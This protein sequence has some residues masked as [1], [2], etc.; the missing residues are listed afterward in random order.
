MCDIVVN[1]VF[2]ELREENNRLSDDLSFE[3]KLNQILEKIKTLAIILKNN[4][5]CSDNI[6]VFRQ[7]NDL[8]ID[9]KLVKA[10]RIGQH[11]QQASKGIL[12]NALLFERLNTRVKGQT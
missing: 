4:C 1:D 2:D 9:Y 5:I 7:L 6:E 10:N 3:K 8:E 11:G 12:E